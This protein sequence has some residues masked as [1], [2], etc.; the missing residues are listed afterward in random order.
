[1]SPTSKGLV[2]KIPSPFSGD[3][4]N[5]NPSFVFCARDIL[6]SPSIRCS[7]GAEFHQQ[8]RSTDQL[9]EWSCS[10]V[11]WQQLSSVPQQG[12][13]PLFILKYTTAPMAAT[14][15]R[16]ISS[17]FIISSLILRSSWIL[18]ALAVY[19]FPIPAPHSRRPSLGFRFVSFRLLSFRS[20]IFPV[21]KFPSSKFPIIHFFCLPVSTVT[22]FTFYTEF[23]RCLL[24][25]LII[26]LL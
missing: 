11:Y 4:L 14:N 6:S 13:H 5:S 16:P 25:H 22:A 7:P 26:H 19:R 12:A 15:N 20:F 8:C 9:A 24:Q 1:M 3:S 17:F 2:A 23:P 21:F 18:S 10:P